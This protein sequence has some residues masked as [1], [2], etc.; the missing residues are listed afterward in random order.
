VVWHRTSSSLG[1]ES[2]LRVYLIARNQWHLRRRHQRGG[3]RG[4]R[5]LAYAL[6][7]NGRT[8]LRYLRLGQR[9]QA[10][11]LALG[12]WDY[13]RGRSGDIRTPDLRLKESSRRQ[14]PAQ[15]CGD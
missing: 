1:A 12:L 9:R 6:Y 14:S 5:G 10:R 8:W 13:W 7:M 11:A 3:L 4:L 2:P 15:R